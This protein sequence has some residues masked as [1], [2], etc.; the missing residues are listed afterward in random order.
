[1]AEGAEIPPARY[2][3]SG[4]LPADVVD[5]SHNWFVSY[6]NYPVYSAP[7]FWRRTALFGPCAMVIAL[8]QSALTWR[9]VDRETAA[10]LTSS[11]VAI[12]LTLVTAGAALATIVRHREMSRR[13]E[14]VAVVLAVVAGV[15][16]CMGVEHIANR[17]QM[18][19]VVPGAIKGGTG[20]KDHAQQ[21]P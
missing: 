3:L 6:R 16:I 13:H 4:R 19:G 14:R 8:L 1:M 11:F 12:W 20:A 18:E 15:A 17:G 7:W 2:P 9:L 21:P 10:I 5:R